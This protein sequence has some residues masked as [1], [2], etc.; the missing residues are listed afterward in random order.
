MKLKDLKRKLNRLSKEQLDQDFIVIAEK[1]T[2]SGMGKA[3]VSNSNLYYTGDDDPSSL[4]TKTELKED[5][6]NK[7]DIENMKI[8]VEKGQFYVELP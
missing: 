8:I 7:E 4:Y 5:Y 1:R 3:R 6:Y 2:F